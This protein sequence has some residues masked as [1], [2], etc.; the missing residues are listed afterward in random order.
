MLIFVRRE[1]ILVLPQKEKGT[2]GVDRVSN[3]TLS[4]LVVFIC[5]VLPFL[6]DGWLKWDE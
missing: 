6:A 2:N 1:F 3:Y 5:E 4:H